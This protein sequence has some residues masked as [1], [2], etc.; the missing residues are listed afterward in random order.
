MYHILSMPNLYVA[1]F[2]LCEDTQRL[3]HVWISV[4]S[5]PQP[6]TLNPNPKPCASPLNSLKHLHEFKAWELGLLAVSLRRSSDFRF[7]AACGVV[8]GG[9]GGFC[10]D[11]W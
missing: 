5:L 8:D 9:C 11:R 1:M 2:H 3:L 4:S 6:S 7:C 10:V